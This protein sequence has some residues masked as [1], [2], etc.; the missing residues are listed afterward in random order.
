MHEDWQK[1]RNFEPS[2]KDDGKG[3]QID[4]A[5]T[6]YSQLPEKWKAENKASALSAVERVSQSKHSGTFDIEQ[7]SD[8]IHKD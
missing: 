4:I 7:A 8:G 6:P 5:N 2:W 3:G 1:A